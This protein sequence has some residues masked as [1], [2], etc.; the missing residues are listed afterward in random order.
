[1]TQPHDALITPHEAAERLYTL[2]AELERHGV[3]LEQ[4]D[5]LAH[6][7]RRFRRHLEGLATFSSRLHDL[8]EEF[9]W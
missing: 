3:P 6:I 5:A 7:S 9:S 2:A 8:A 4:L 1:M